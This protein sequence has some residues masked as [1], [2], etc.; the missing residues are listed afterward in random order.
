MLAIPNSLKIL[1]RAARVLQGRDLWQTVQIDRQALRLGNHGADWTISPRNLSEQSVVY[2]FGVG[3][4]IS[5]DLELIKR[6]A[7]TV[8]AFDPTPRSTAW[9][10]NQTLPAKFRFQ[11]LGIADYN[12]TAKFSPPHNPEHVSHTMVGNKTSAL[13]VEVPVQRL[14]T[15]MKNLGHDRIDILKMD[16]EGAEYAVLEDLLASQIGVYQL[17]VE[18]HHRWPQIGARKTKEIIRELNLG[19]YQIF[20]VSPTGEEFSFCKVSEP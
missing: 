3:E 5:F 11:A 6:F 10:A 8:H 14:S 17:L 18:F 4:D 2:S 15:I 20:S 12:G 19:G 1:R 7:V 16:I 13:G 9:I